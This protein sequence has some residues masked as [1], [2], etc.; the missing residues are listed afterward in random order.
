M[1]LER[2]IVIDFRRGGVGYGRIGAV[3]RFFFTQVQA[4]KYA[5]VMK[6]Y[7]AERLVRCFGADTL[8]GRASS[9]RKKLPVVGH[10]RTEIIENLAGDYHRAAG[11]IGQRIIGTILPEKE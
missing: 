10:L 9:G 11:G 5:A 3:N 1:R 2:L 4:E 6:I 7:Q 8:A